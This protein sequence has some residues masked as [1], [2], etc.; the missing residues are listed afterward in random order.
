MSL[1]KPD[2]SVARFRVWK[3]N[4][5]E[6]GTPITDD[7]VHTFAGQGIDDL[8]ATIR[9]DFSKY[10]FH[11]QILT[12]NGDYFIDPYARSETKKYI[13]YFRVDLKGG[14]RPPDIVESQDSLIR[15][16]Q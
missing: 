9:F 11:A 14:G 10:G 7:Y 16:R 12:P 1:I 8:Y 4:V 15:R 6:A 2:G 3:S 13:S 5:Q